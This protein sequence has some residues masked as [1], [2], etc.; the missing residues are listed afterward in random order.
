MIVVWF[1]PLIQQLKFFGHCLN[2]FGCCPKHFIINFWLRNWVIQIFQ[3]F[4][5]KKIQSLFR[6]IS[7]VAQKFSIVWLRVVQ[8]PQLFWQL[9]ILVVVEKNSITKLNNWKF[10]WSN[11]S[12]EKNWS[13]FQKKF[14]WFILHP[15]SK[16]KKT[17]IIVE[18]KFWLRPKKVL[19]P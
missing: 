10:Q 4:F 1:P 13:L 14:K 18:N 12:F 6:N 5:E 11:W 9:K 2:S 3:S 8:S 17:L 7:I 19:S 16:D 15:W